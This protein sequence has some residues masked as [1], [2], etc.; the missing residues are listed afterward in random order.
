MILGETLH[1][2]KKVSNCAFLVLGF[3]FNLGYFSHFL[4]KYRN[5]GKF[6]NCH[7]K[8]ILK[9]NL[10]NFKCLNSEICQILREIKGSL[11]YAS[12]QKIAARSSP[13]LVSVLSLYCLCLVLRTR[14]CSNF[15]IIS[16]Y[17]SFFCTC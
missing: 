11:L 1:I 13:C 8:Q 15:L 3:V 16:V 2:H 5:Q 10:T 17:L 9:V 14:L 4:L 12:S 7:D 6:V